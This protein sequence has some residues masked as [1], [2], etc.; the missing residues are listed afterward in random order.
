MK[1]SRSTMAR[2]V[3]DETV[4]LDVASG[5]YFA[6]NDVGGFI[7]NYL[8]HDCSQEDLVDAVV[9]AYGIDQPQASADV[10][11]L[12]DQLRKRRLIET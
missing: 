7:W 12:L 4:I 6:L 11:E 1:R 3:D 2:R 10:G 8:E 5:R 9:E